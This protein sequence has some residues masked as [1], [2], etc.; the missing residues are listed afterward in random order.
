[1]H[2]EIL[3]NIVGVLDRSEIRHAVSA[4]MFKPMLILSF[5][6]FSV[7][8][9]GAAPKRPT[10]LAPTT[11]KYVE[12]YSTDLYEAQLEGSFDSLM[13]EKAYQKRRSGPR[14][15]YRGIGGVADAITGGIQNVVDTIGEVNNEGFFGFNGGVGNVIGSVLRLVN[16]ALDM[17]SFVINSILDGRDLFASHRSEYPFKYD[18]GFD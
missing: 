4:V 6:V 14:V 11:M 9:I 15:R 1:M 3:R 8:L 12:E 17:A 16:L 5:I 2:K 13:P 7:T 10:I 18:E